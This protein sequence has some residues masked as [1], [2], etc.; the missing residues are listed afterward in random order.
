LLFN[1]GSSFD[2]G[3]ITPTLPAAADGEEGPPFK[4]Y[5]LRDNLDRR[6]LTATSG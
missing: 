1:G 4:F 2:L 5:E 3:W 6:S